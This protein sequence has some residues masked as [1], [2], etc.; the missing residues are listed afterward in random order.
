V[1]LQTALGDGDLGSGSLNTAELNSLVV[2]ELVH[3]TESE[4]EAAGGSV[5]GEDVDRATVVGEAPASTA[6]VRV[7]AGES[8][9]TANEGEARDLALSLPAKAG[10]EA[11]GAVGAAHSRKVA[12]AVVVAAVIGD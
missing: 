6:L 1:P 12:G 3:G 5:D 2:G 7:P 8:R 11:V 4:V 10:H 9:G